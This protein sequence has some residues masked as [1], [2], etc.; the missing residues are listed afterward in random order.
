MISSDMQK[1]LGFA[2]ILKMLFFGTWMIV[3]YSII[4]EFKM[5]GMQF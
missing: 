1:Y 5:V 2:F 4:A 3:E